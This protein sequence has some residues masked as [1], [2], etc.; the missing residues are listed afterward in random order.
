MNRILS[1][2]PASRLPGLAPLARGHSAADP[3]V[4]PFLGTPAT[5]EAVAERARAVL[6]RHVP[7]MGPEGEEPLAGLAAGRRAGIFTGQQVGLFT[8]PLLTFGKA[9]AALDL[10]SSLDRAGV[11]AQAAFWCAAEDHD[12]VEVSRFA[13]PGQ[14]GPV[15]L[16][17][18]PGPLQTNRR[19]VGELPVVEDV[20]DLL[21][22][23]LAQAGGE[24][25]AAAVEALRSQTRGATYRDA[26]VA[27]LSWLLGPAPLAF[28]DAAR[29][30]LKPLLAPLAARLVRDRAE[31]RRLLDARAEALA[32]AGYP[33]QV[34]SEKGALPLFALIGGER[35]LLRERNG[36]LELKG[37]PGESWPAEEVAAR[38]EEGRWLPSFAAL[39]RPVAASLLY[40]VAA[41]VLGPAEISY[42]AQALPLFDW[43]GLVPPVLV[44]RPMVA[45]AGPAERRLLGKLGLPVEELLAGESAILARRGAEASG[46]LLAEIEAVGEQAS[47][48]LGALETRLAALDPS[49]PRALGQTRENV[50]FAV[51][52]LVE[53]VRAAAGRADEAYSRSVRRLTQALV[54]G[55]A[56]AERVF[57][58]VPWLVRHGRDE[59]AAAMREGIRWDAAGLTVV[60]IGGDGADAAP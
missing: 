59:L 54:P 39:A 32:A 44:P 31:V 10:A 9:L 8:G 19:P 14:D 49:L 34:V 52:K 40:P 29:A 24:P 12:L 56:L 17:P 33:L 43:A 15:E 11:G 55:G 37:R 4:A 42:W 47:T 60:G 3:A 35:L 26:F 22:R 51:G 18:D 7:R 16:G 28:V 36:R 48:R 45:L 38:F 41:A 30:D 57:T 2:V 46:D 1:F 25:E 27:T 21:D 23:A 5:L 50:R 6:S 53:R 13:V 58:P 20:D